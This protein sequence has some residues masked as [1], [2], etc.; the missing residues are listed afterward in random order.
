MCANGKKPATDGK[1]CTD[2]KCATTNCSLCAVSAGI[3]ICAMCSS[4]YA[5]NESTFTCVA[6]KTA[7]CWM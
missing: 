3:E 1:T 4:G 6:E 2:T 7:N 5:L